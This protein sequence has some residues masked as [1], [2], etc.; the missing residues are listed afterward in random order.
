MNRRERPSNNDDSS[1]ESSIEVRVIP[2]SQRRPATAEEVAA[3]L[4]TLLRNNNAANFAARARE[5]QDFNFQPGLDSDIS[6]EPRLLAG[7]D[8]ED[9]NI[10]RTASDTE[11][12]V[13]SQVKPPACTIRIK[14]G[15]VWE[16]QCVKDVATIKVKSKDFEVRAY[17][18][19]PVNQEITQERTLRGKYKGELTRIWSKAPGEATFEL[20]IR[21]K[22]KPKQLFGP[23]TE[24]KTRALEQ[25]LKRKREDSSDSSQSLVDF[26]DPWQE[27]TH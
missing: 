27:E 20:E 24:E 23:L 22:R 9:R 5:A 12:S 4:G 11:G 16:T 1:T 3:D 15:S 10:A 19:P 6:V 25:H 13:D 7:R 18:V 2:L 14:F 8:W 26:R 21:K 17:T